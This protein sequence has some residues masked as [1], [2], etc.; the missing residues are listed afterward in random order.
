[1]KYA[2]VYQPNFNPYFP[3][4]T[5]ACFDS[6]QQAREFVG[7]LGVEFESEDDIVVVELNNTKEQ[8]LEKIKK[9]NKE[10]GF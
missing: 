5:I 2:I 3:C 8:A 10:F 4:E 6:E 9:V 7:G 1:M